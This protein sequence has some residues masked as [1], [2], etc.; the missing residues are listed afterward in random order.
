[1][2][3][4]VCKRVYIYKVQ[5]YDEYDKKS[6]TFNTRDFKIR[7]CFPRLKTLI[8]SGGNSNYTLAVIYMPASVSH[9]LF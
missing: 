9:G 3:L 5:G 6:I 4:S 2:F 1:M 8:C 7:S